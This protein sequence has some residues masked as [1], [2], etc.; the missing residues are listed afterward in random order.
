MPAIAQ[1]PTAWSQA[2]ELAVRARRRGLTFEQFWE[3]AMRPG[4]PPITWR[5]PPSK[6]PADAIV[7]PN[8]TK[9]RKDDQAAMNAVREGWARAYA[10]RRQ[11]K[12]EAALPRLLSLFD[13]AATVLQ[14]AEAAEERSAL[15]DG[16]TDGDALLSAA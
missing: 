3:A 14:I 7:W 4:R 1:Y 5:V 6:R 15:S 12:R 16:I 8:D 2:L 10:L 13:R 11:L 9:T